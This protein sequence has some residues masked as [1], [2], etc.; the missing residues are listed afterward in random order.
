MIVTGHKEFDRATNGEGGLITHGN[1]ISDSMYGFHVRGYFV[2]ECNGFTRPPGELQQFDLKPATEG[3][4]QRF[5]PVRRWITASEHFKH[6]SGWCYLIR[7]VTKEG[8]V[9]IHGA[10]VTDYQNRLL[11]EFSREQIERHSTSGTRKSH[12]VMGR[13]KPLLLNLGDAA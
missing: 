1:V 13:V 4:G 2:T 8:G 5:E 3:Y 10:L 9:V 6:N 7:H 12:T 11:K